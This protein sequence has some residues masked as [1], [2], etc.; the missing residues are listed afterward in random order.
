MPNRDKRGGLR[1]AIA[2]QFKCAFHQPISVTT[3]VSCNCDRPAAATIR[4]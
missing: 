1:Q 3:T 2:H 4:I